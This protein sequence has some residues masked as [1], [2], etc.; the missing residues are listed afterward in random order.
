MESDEHIRRST[1]FRQIAATGLRG[2][3]DATR[4]AR[5]KPTL[6]GLF[7][8]FKGLRMGFNPDHLLKENNKEE[9]EINT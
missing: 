9:Q 7:W 1:L 8:S 4:A 5:P 6:G 3:P 2:E